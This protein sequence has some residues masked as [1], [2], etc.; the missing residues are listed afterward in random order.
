[1]RTLIY[2]FRIAWDEFVYGG[3][4]LSLGAVSIVATTAII[5]G[6]K[7]TWDLLLI[8]YLEVESAYLYNRY[9][10]FQKDFLTNPERTSHVA[11]YV[12]AIPVFIVASLL[13]MFGIV[14]YCAKFP[15]LVFVLVLFVF[16]IL[17]SNGLKQFTSK[18]PGFKSVFVAL[19]WAMLA[20]LFV[21][22]YSLPINL[23]VILVTCFVFLRQIVNTSFFDIKDIESDK[24]EGLL[25][26]AIVLG[27][28]RLIALLVFLTWL[29]ALPILAGF[30]LKLFPV[31]SLFLLLT[32]PYSFYYLHKVRQEHINIS[33]LYNVIV[34]G[35]FM[36]WW[37][38]LMLAHIFL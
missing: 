30:Y 24:K 32:I 10:E 35:E 38:V 1:M 20:I 9:K 8:V 5:L 21:V 31:T 23:A 14:V 29:T 2:F 15:A 6:Y 13:V 27:K 26:L 34:D 28:D 18:M 4:L 17:Y 19:M 16:G 25:T 11:T 22:Y 36:L 7:T 33:F 3:H 12:K 37:P